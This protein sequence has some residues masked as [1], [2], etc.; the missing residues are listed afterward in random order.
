MYATWQRIV[1]PSE[2]ASQKGYENAF[3]WYSEAYFARS[4]NG[5]ESWEPARAI[6]RE[7]GRLTQTIGNQVEVL[8]DGTLIN[9]FNLIRAI[10][11]PAGARAAT[12]SR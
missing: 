7:Q 4:T 9:G 3:S 8:P 5:G 12:T 6:Y 1:S 11:Q 2:R 10:S